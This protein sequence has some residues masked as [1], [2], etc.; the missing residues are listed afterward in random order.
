MLT[1]ALKWASEDSDYNR[2]NK[3]AVE[4]NNNVNSKY[5]AVTEKLIALAAPGQPGRGLLT[6]G[7]GGA[8]I[9]GLG[10]CDASL[11]VMKTSIEAWGACSTV[12]LHEKDAYTYHRYLLPPTTL[13][14]TEFHDAW[15]QSSRKQLESAGLLTEYFKH[16][17]LCA[18]CSISAAVALEKKSEKMAST[19][20]KL[21]EY[22]EESGAWA[23]E[24]NGIK[25]VR[26]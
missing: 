22:I 1:N 25:S 18:A 24:A 14:A 16:T 23:P 11:P 13:Q 26:S 4:Y 15:F 21:R 2:L 12:R 19:E 7:A 20:E 17:D 5:A 10:G 9:G 6:S 8:A 3:W